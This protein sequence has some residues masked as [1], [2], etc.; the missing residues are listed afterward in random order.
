[1]ARPAVRGEGLAIAGII[2]SG[3]NLALCVLLIPLM[4]AITLPAMARAREA[5]RRASCQNNLKQLGLVM[6]MFANESKGEYYP[7][8]SSE[9]GKLM[10]AN[11]SA[12]SKSPIYPEFLTE[13]L[14]MNCPSDS[15]SMESTDTKNPEEMLDDQCYFYLGYAVMSD[16]DV[17]A[18]A[19]AYRATTASGGEF[20]DNLTSA[21]HAAGIGS[22]TVYRLKEGVEVKITNDKNAS[23]TTQADI[24]VLIERVGHHLPLGANVLYMDGHVEFI[25]YPGKWPMTERT[26]SVLQA[27]DG[28]FWPPKEVDFD[29]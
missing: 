25:K 2:L 5:A 20:E 7:V 24:P 21:A 18:F 15:D 3:I 28:G 23:V 17:E 8:L 13:T 1:K 29:S 4:G 10:F 12:V 19:E 27:L 6:K 11:T 14:L 26:I 22:G 16:D 9:P